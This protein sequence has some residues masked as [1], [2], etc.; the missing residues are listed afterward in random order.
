MPLSDSEYINLAGYYNMTILRIGENV[1]VHNTNF[2]GLFENRRKLL[3]VE[4]PP[5]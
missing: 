5:L 4:T 1:K 2:S 3:Y